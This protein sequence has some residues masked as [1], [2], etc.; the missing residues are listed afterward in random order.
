MTIES[1]L[2]P[3]I[4]Y[5]ATYQITVKRKLNEGW[6]ARFNG[7]VITVENNLEGKPES[8]L[9]CKVKDQAELAGI[10]NHLNRLDLPILQVTHIQTEKLLPVKNYG[11]IV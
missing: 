6:I 8:T 3:G 10:L 2:E 4:N 1:L 11:L 7:T 9:T 5:R